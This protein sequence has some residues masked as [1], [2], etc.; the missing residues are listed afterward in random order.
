[1]ASAVVLTAVVLT[2]RRPAQIVAALR[3]T[4]G[5]HVLNAACAGA[6]YALVLAALRMAPVAYV[7]TLREVSVVFGVLGGW[8]LLDEPFGGARTA[9]AVGV[10]TGIVV[11]MLATIG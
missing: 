11:L 8:L 3:Q 6:A 7:A 4:P 5:A 9:G 1:V 10:A 2:R